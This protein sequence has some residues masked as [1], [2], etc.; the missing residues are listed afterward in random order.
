M[1]Y[2][3]KPKLSITEVLHLA[4]TIL[5][6]VSTASLTLL[7]AAFRGEAGHKLYFKHV[8][9]TALRTMNERASARQIQAINPSTIEAYTAFAKAQGFEPNS[10]SFSTTSAKLLWLGKPEASNIL[11]CLHGGGFVYPAAAQLKWCWDLRKQS[12]QEQ[13]YAIALLAYSLA[14][15][16][17]YPAQLAQTVAALRYLVEEKSKDPSKISIV[18]D[19]AGALLGL[20]VISHLLHSHPAI[21]PLTLA[22]PLAGIA[23][24]SP[25]VTPR[26]LADSAKRNSRKDV[27]SKRVLE[28]WSAYAL[29]SA[30]EDLYNTPSAATAEWWAGVQTVVKDL[31]LTAGR[32]EVLFDDI[33][34]FSAQLKSSSPSMSI[35]FVNETHDQALMDPIIGIKE[36]CESSAAVKSWLVS[37]CQ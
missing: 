4:F 22:A 9:H 32:H 11:L 29:G 37:K 18:G 2:Q 31:I 21:Q 17:Q 19:S 16:A 24:I 20:G 8:A 6:T 1:D 15:D 26:V 35:V 34:S 36:D 25:W 3:S 33:E 14:P 7:T 5:R 12:H 30:Q 23:L 10:T 13:N 28:K 27:V